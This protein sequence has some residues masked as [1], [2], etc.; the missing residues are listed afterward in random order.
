MKKSQLR[1]L[2]RETIKS[3]MMN[4]GSR[5][6]QVTDGNGRLVLITDPND[7]EDFLAGEEVYGEDK[8]GESIAVYLDS[9]L[10]YQMAEGMSN[11]A[12]DPVGKEDDDINN[13]GK[14]DKTDKYLANKRAKIAKSIK[15]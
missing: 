7:I 3:S 9:A 15:R 11:E 13:D 4:K 1:Q 8:D 5:T 2:I 12:L 10:D 14:V 6:L